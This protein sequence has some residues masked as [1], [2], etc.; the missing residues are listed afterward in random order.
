M[1][2]Y[3]FE[4]L[5]LLLML[6]VCCVA[7][8]MNIDWAGV[9]DIHDNYPLQ[10][11]QFLTAFVLHTA[12]VMSIRNGTQMIKFL[13]Y[14]SE[15]CNHPVSAFFLGVLVILVNV[16]CEITNICSVLSLSEVE[17]V[18]ASFVGFSALF[19][20]QD[21]YA[22]QRTNFK[23]RKA[24]VP[25][26]LIIVEDPARIYSVPDEEIEADRDSKGPR[27]KEKMLGRRTI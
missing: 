8:L 10:V 7:I 5:F 18:L 9:V 1:A 13:V 19:E 4:S 12:S 11:C 25:N 3:Y 16:L 24:V 20:A 14:H 15:E 2:E 27:K 6:T 17:A 21:F 22:W 26:P 23:I